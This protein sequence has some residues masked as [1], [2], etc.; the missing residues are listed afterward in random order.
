LKNIDSLQFSSPVFVRRG[1]SVSYNGNFMIS[2]SLPSNFSIPNWLDGPLLLKTEKTLLFSGVLVVPVL[3]ILEA[4]KVTSV[5]PQYFFFV[6]AGSLLG[7]TFTYLIQMNNTVQEL[8]T[9]E[10]LIPRPLIPQPIPT[11]PELRGRSIAQMT[12]NLQQEAQLNVRRPASPPSHF[13]FEQ[14]IFPKS[15]SNSNNTA[16]D[17]LD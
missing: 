1:T 8:P 13:K 10:P 7:L 9:P 17:S 3:K 12:S 15:N 2:P 11:P 14:Y 5:M 4:L 16:L 6:G